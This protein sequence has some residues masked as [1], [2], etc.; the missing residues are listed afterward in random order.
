MNTLQKN[1]EIFKIPQSTQKSTWSCTN[2]SET[3]LFVLIRFASTQLFAQCQPPLDMS[4][5]EKRQIVKIVHF[6]PLLF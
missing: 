3:A 1:E 2:Q 5:F 6:L 4:S